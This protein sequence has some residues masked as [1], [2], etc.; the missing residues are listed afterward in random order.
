MNYWRR[1]ALVIDRHN[2]LKLMSDYILE[3]F[4]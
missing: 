1:H 2:F 4:V 3:V